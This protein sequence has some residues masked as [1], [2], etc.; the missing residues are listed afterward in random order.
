M[1]EVDPT[2]QAVCYLL[3]ATQALVNYL[4]CMEAVTNSQTV[5]Q[6][7]TDC[8]CWRRSG[9]KAFY[10]NEG[11]PVYQAWVKETDPA[12]ETTTDAPACS[13]QPTMLHG[14]T[15]IRDG[16]WMTTCVECGENLIASWVPAGSA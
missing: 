9:W 7:T 15:W 13:H 8:T 6:E 14:S 2:D 3:A 4:E 11:C 5:A 12:Q 10:H 16:V 1:K